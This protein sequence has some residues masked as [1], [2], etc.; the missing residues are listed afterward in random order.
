MKFFKTIQ[1][2]RAFL[3]QKK[4]EGGQIGLVP[5]M[6]ALH[7]GHFELIKAAR[8]TSDV[9]VVSIFIN[10]IQFNKK[11]DFDKYP[12]NLDKDIESLEGLGCD[13]VFAPDEKEMYPVSGIINFGVGYFDQVMEGKFRPGHFSG[14]G[15]IVCKLLNIISPDRAYFGQKDLQQL[16]LIKKMVQELNIGTE[17]VEIATIR[18]PSGLAMSSRNERLNTEQKEIAAGIYQGLVYLKE[19]ISVGADIKT[20]IGEVKNYFNNMDGFELEYLEVVDKDQLLPVRNY[21]D[22]AE[23]ALCVAGYVGTVRLLDNICINSKD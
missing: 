2:V 12:R 16:V 13:V 3:S 15:L 20:A 10:P 4:S 5:T 9:V 1:D 14:V 22:C 21:A 8:L 7:Q 6:G 23:I 17:V 11:E 19:K 18:E